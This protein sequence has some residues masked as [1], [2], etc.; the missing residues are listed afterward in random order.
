MTLF[1]CVWNW[2]AR[3]SCMSENSPLSVCLKLFCKT[4]LVKILP[5][6]C[7]KLICNTAC[8]NIL[9]FQRV[10]N[11]S[12]KT[13]H[14][15]ILFQCL[16]LI[17]KIS[18]SFH[19]LTVSCLIAV[20][21]QQCQ[22]DAW[23]CA[24]GGEE[25]N[26]G[27]RAQIRGRGWG[28][29]AV[30]GA[31]PSLADRGLVLI[32]RDLVVVKWMQGTCKNQYWVA[33][34]GAGVGA[35]DVIQPQFNPVFIFLKKNN[36]K[37]CSTFLSLGSLKMFS[38][39][40]KILNTMCCLYCCFLYSQFFFMQCILLLNHWYA[41]YEW[42]VACGQL[43]AFPACMSAGEN[44]MSTT[45]STPSHHL[46]MKPESVLS[47]CQWLVH[48]H[49]TLHWARKALFTWLLGRQTTFY[50][51]FRKTDYFLPCF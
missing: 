15:K 28:L 46:G 39:K 27:P 47:Q 1:P 18:D 40:P 19:A 21:L 26:S 5:F 23:R 35:W 45:P 49:W 41:V 9:L 43:N 48:F 8:L 36:N 3:L 24:C 7:L 29:P 38:R 42:R 34:S 11:W 22:A 12:A 37:I 6:Q 16:K 20:S 2:S 17:C 50:L 10:W 44:M 14:L 32:D 30:T 4:A 33:W 25:A 51:A 31:E 13:A